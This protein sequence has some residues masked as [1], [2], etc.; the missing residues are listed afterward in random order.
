MSE[1]SPTLRLKLFKLQGISTQTDN[2]VVH[3]GNLS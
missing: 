1:G 2:K 3:K